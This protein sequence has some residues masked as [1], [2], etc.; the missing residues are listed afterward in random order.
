MLLCSVIACL[1]APAKKTTKEEP[2]I[3]VMIHGSHQIYSFTVSLD[4]KYIYTRGKGEIC[5]WD[6]RDRLLLA[7]WPIPTIEILPHPIDS[8]LIYLRPDKEDARKLSDAWATDDYVIFDWTKGEALGYVGS[9]GAYAEG[10]SDYMI[11]QVFDDWLVMMPYANPDNRTSIGAVN[12]N[13]G[14]ARTNHNDSLLAT[15]GMMPAV[16]DLKFPALRTYINYTAYL[17]NDSTLHFNDNNLFRFPYS[18]GYVGLTNFCNSYFIPG[19][20]D[21]MLAAVG[22]NTTTWNSE[23]HLLEEIPMR[24]QPT[25]ALSFKGDTIIAVTHKGVHR[26][27]ASGDFHELEAFRK[28]ANN[29]DFFAIAGPY[30]GDRYLVGCGS[31]WYDG[32]TV[33]E[34]AYGSDTPTRVANKD[35]TYISDIKI[36]PRHDYA[37]IVNGMH[38]ISK[39]SLRGDSLRYVWHRGYP[40]IE[41]EKFNRCEV[42]PDETIVVGTDRGTLLFWG[43]DAPKPSRADHAHSASINCISMSND[44]TR[45]FVSDASGQIS[46]WDVAS[47]KPLMSLYMINSEAG[48]YIYITPDHYYR[49]TPEAYKFM[50]F[51]RDGQAYSFEQFDLR[52]NRPDIVAQRLGSDPEVVDLLHKAWLKRLRRAGVDEASLATDYHVPTASITNAEALPAIT[53]SPM[54]D[55]DIACNDTRYDIKDVTL[56][57]NGVPFAPSSAAI[58]GKRAEFTE[59]LQ[60]ATGNNEIVLTCRNAQGTE[61]LRETVNISYHPKQPQQ[62][63]I[64]VASVG[65][66][67]YGSSA[68]NLTYADKDADDFA[69]LI[70]TQAKGS[71]RN[72]KTLTIA[73]DEFTLSAMPLISEFLSQAGRDDVVILFFAG[74]G[75]LDQQLDYYLGT[76]GMDFANPSAAGVAYDDFIRLLDSSASVNRYCFIDACHSGELDKEDYLAVNTVE[77]PQGEE[78]VFRAAGH[79]AKAKDE[80]ERV[81][82]LIDAMFAD[83]RYGMGATVLS[84]A[85]G[86]QLAVESAQWSN[87]LFT[88]C[89]KK[90]L[91]TSEADSNHDG[92]ITLA[93]WISYTSDKVTE[94]SQGSQTPSVRSQNRHSDLKLK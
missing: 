50:N 83:T 6:L 14:S 54:V 42:L 12:I 40:D 28:T 94:L 77:M 22:R 33:I 24:A 73:D 36:A 9:T 87:G 49:T 82:Q 86:E 57:L 89:L 61:S 63:T 62:P 65:V 3:K 5:V 16:W 80:V 67:D 66:S 79:S 69:K 27:I 10:A 52:N 20:D 84:S 58:R 43:K 41:H 8:R 70:A 17:Q 2:E 30:Q 11:G 55:L 39:L 90:G 13:P 64:Y 45:M 4:E 32:H 81:N 29:D 68:Y 35:L 7:S 88:Y 72:V 76:H 53:D 15:S 75:V 74:H 37:I 38:A 78:L 23:G 71:G 26:R 85:G 51:V 25:T 56:T 92:H 19:G 46:I 93:E 47:L 34:G 91:E 18:R 59:T 31:K 21:V 60:L 44:S 48:G 1:A